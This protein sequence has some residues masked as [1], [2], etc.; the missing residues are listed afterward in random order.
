MTLEPALRNLGQGGDVIPRSY[1]KA[2]TARTSTALRRDH[3]S[4]PTSWHTYA[5][6]T[7]DHHDTLM[8]N[9]Q[10]RA[11]HEWDDPSLKSPVIS[12]GHSAYARM[13][14]PFETRP[15]PDPSH[16][17]SS[18][19]SRPNVCEDSGP[20]SNAAVFSEAVSNAEAVATS[21]ALIACAADFDLIDLS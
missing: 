1:G 11:F 18:T 6:E 2:S 20:S 3:R 5:E 4:S 9:D 17:Q 14:S 7:V 13:T 21:A 12:R 16:L 8:M 10:H 15:A 19:K